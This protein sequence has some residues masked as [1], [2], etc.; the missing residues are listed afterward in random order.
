MSEQTQT[1]EQDEAW[2]Q[3][4]FEKERAEFLADHEANRDAREIEAR[5]EQVQEEW[6]QE[7]AELGD[8]Y[9]ADHYE[10]DEAGL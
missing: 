7:W 3:V 6:G 9:E 10:Q 2:N 1:P 4:E 5:H 8:Q